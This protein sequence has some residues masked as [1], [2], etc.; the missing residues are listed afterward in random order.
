MSENRTDD[1]KRMYRLMTKVSALSEMKKYFSA[2]I[3]VCIYI[4]SNLL[5][6]NI[7][8]FQLENRPCNSQRPG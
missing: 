3:I 1:L 8:G 2:Y 5:H 6:V 4:N 7:V